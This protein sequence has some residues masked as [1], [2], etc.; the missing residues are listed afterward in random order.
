MDIIVIFILGIGCYMFYN[1]FVWLGRKRLIEN[2][3]TSK[4]RSLA[5]G[6]VEV[7]GE[8]V[9]AA[10]ALPIDGK[11]LKGPLSKKDCVY[12]RYVVEE[13]RSSGKHSRWVTVKA[14]N[15]GSLF[16]LKD[17]TGAV[18]VNPE[19]ATL[20]IS[21][22]FVFESGLGKDPPAA[23]KEFLAEQNIRFEGFLGINK[24]M[25]FTEYLLAPADK[26]YIMGTAADNPHVH[27]ATGQSNVDDIMIQKGNNKLY[28]I[29]DK[30]EKE[31]L[32]SLK[33]QVPLGLFGGAALI[34]IGLSVMLVYFGLF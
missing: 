33:W 10:D 32:K 26:V 11:L 27:E 16:F 13:Y 25:R 22:D 9:P 29:S 28:F 7:F 19:S 18:L 15:S 21:S 31:I 23:V 30:P 17:N 3:P 34:I 6:L 5:M 4:V 12:Y 24:K 2:T 20:N 8:V 14:G 1:G